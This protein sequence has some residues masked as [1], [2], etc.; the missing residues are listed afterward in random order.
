MTFEVGV[1]LGII[2][3]LFIFCLL[4][5]SS[6]LRNIEKKI[7]NSSPKVIQ[8]LLGE[9]ANIVSS[10]ENM[11]REI[12]NSVDKVKNGV[13][14]MENRASDAN[15]VYEATTKNLAGNIEKTVDIL[16]EMKKIISYFN[17]KTDSKF[18]KQQE[19]VEK[20][21][22]EI[23]Q[24]VNSTVR[25]NKDEIS[26]VLSGNKSSFNEM[27]EN[28]SQTIRRS[29]VDIMAR[30]IDVVK[31]H[32]DV[33]SQQ[34]YTTSVDVFSTTHETSFIELEKEIYD[35]NKSLSTLLIE[36]QISMIQL[37]E[38]TNLQLIESRSKTT[39]ATIN[40][41]QE[42]MK[43]INK[44]R[45]LDITLNRAK[46]S[47]GIIKKRAGID[48]ILDSA[49]SHRVDVESLNESFAIAAGIPSSDKS[50]EIITEE[51]E[52]SLDGVT[53]GENS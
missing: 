46:E 2:S 29:F 43:G 51:P 24:S 10:S 47:L 13:I 23:R 18:N 39:N 5:I 21:I 32:M 11:V 25:E 30:E 37:V 4:G 44:E 34:I 52:S 20:L 28:V 17:E 45:S 27:M 38:S 1:Y 16:E 6:N 7:D 3:L 41:L 48:E 19:E 36:N 26:R 33:L 49:E 50:T 35:M 53:A 31:K 22:A 14:S 8:A 42:K 12:T 15:K 9:M 40:S